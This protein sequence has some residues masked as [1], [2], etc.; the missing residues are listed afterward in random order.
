MR[1]ARATD[2]ADGEP[3]TSTGADLDRGGD[4]GSE[5]FF[6]RLA[7]VCLGVAADGGPGLN[8][9]LAQSRSQKS[10]GGRRFRLVGARW[11]GGVTLESNEYDDND[12]DGVLL[13][14][15]KSFCPRK[16]TASE[17]RFLQMCG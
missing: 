1:T 7:G 4:V 13:V 6:S 3:G 14:V 17:M 10:R 16:F 2:I 15:A 9:R 11:V 8:R 12:G 5:D